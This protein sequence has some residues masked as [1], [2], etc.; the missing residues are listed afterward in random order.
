MGGKPLI[1]I[2]RI[3][4]WLPSRYLDS[5]PRGKLETTLLIGFY[6]IKPKPLVDGGGATIAPPPLNYFLAAI[7][8]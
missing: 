1:L 3:F 6:L 7:N 5:S 8:E 2:F 4:R